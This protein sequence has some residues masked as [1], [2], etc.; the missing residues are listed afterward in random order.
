M[1]RRHTTR[2]G[3]PVPLSSDHTAEFL[4]PLNYQNPVLVYEMYRMGF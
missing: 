4:Y 1:P 2:L 3:P